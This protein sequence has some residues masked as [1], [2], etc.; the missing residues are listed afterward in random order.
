M[1]VVKRLV[2]NIRAEDPQRLIIADGLKWGREPVNG[3]AGL[4]IAQS[5]RGYE[6]VQISHYQASWMH[7]SDTWPEPTWPLKLGEN[8]IVDKETL[9]KE[10]IQ[11]WKRL[12]QK[13][14]GIHVGEWGA[15]NHTPHKVVLAWMRDCLAL[16]KEA[17]WGWALWNLQGGF[18]VLDSQRADVEYET[19]AATSST[20][21]C[22]TCCDRDRRHGLRCAGGGGHAGRGGLRGDAETAPEAEREQA[23]GDDDKL[24]GDEDH[25]PFEGGIHEAV[26]VQPDA[27]HVHAKPG[28]TGDNVAEDREVHDAAITHQVAP[29]DVK[30]D[31]V[32]DH[33]EQ[34]AV[35]LRV[36]APE[37]APGLIGPD[38]TQ[39]RA[40]KAEQSGEADNAINHRCQGIAQ[41]AWTDSRFS[42]L[43]CATAAGCM[44]AM[45]CRLGTAGDAGCVLAPLSGRAALR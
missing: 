36:P 45:P 33:D 18:G 42:P 8:R 32:P 26:G 13:G 30:D 15:F 24:A 7:G 16:W 39:D 23:D 27:E 25:E 34:G 3:L 6:P 28:E 38:A 40:D 37:P 44:A 21:R 17:G 41:R 43:D 2:E 11:P 20:A 14:V 22:W 35:F 10:H 9:A 19:S 31:R 29:A 5:T 12:E 4:G 1:R